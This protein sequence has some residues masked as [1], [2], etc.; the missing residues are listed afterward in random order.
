MH[1]HYG[2]SRRLV[3]RGAIGESNHSRTFFIRQN[4]KRVLLFLF[5]LTLS[6]EIHMQNVDLDFLISHLFHCCLN[7]F[8]STFPLI[9]VLL[10]TYT[11]LFNCRVLVIDNVSMIWLFGKFLPKREIALKVMCILSWLWLLH[12]VL[13]KM[14]T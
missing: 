1:F 9:Q 7:S 10:R 4:L 6:L 12:I 2:I 13:L 5:G 3:L 14:Q 11:F 8:I